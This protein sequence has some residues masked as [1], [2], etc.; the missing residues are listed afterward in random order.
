[1][2]VTAIAN[3]KGGTGKTTTAVN[4]AAAAALRGRRVLLVDMDKQGSATQWLNHSPDSDLLVRALL[5]D[6]DPESIV[7]PTSV[8]GRELIRASVAVQSEPVTSEPGSQFLLR[9]M[10]AKLAPRDWVIL[11]APGDLGPITIMTL[12]A[13]TDVLVPVPAGAM[14][15]DE[16]PKVQA[17]IS[18]VQARLNPGLTMAGVLLTQV[19]MY[20]QH[21]SVLAREVGEQLRVDFAAGEVLSSV[22][23]DDMRFRE[24][25]AARQPMAVYDPGGK[26]DQDY[27]AALDEL[28]EREAINVVA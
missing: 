17:T 25:P 23:R 22:I 10:L 2:R 21:S 5:G 3:P 13:A 9:E 4:L 8:E 14:E 6:V 7:V 28:T 15:L 18:K 19:R 16:V 20:G 1:M 11:D 27:R 24:A 12:T 26:G